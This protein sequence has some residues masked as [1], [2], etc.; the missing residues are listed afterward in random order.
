[1]HSRLRLQALLII[2]VLSI[3]IRV[4]SADAWNSPAFTTD[5]AILRQAAQ[6]VQ[7]EKHAEATVLLNELHFKFE[8]SKM[9]ETR[10][11]IHRIENQDGVKNW[12][13]I[14]GRWEAWH[15]EKPEIKARVI[16]A[17]G[18]VHW[19]DPKTL[20]DFPVHED[21]PDVYSDERSYGGPLPAVASGSI[22]EEEIAVRDMAPLF[23][24]GT[25]HRWILGW[26]APVSKT[27]VVLIHPVSLPLHYEVHLLLDATIAKSTDGGLEIITL[28]QGSLHAYTEE[29][30]HAPSD[31]VLYPE[32]EF[33]TGTSWHQVASE[34]ARLSDDQLRSADVQT[35]IAK[36][37][38]KQVADRRIHVRDRDF[39]DPVCLALYDR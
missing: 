4:S 21:A 34:H 19:L 11:L 28:E 20:N 38:A 5:P 6:A 2:V 37:K 27:R 17:E 13:E 1:M 8:H 12:A 9:M 26:G 22:V 10:H 23:A 7:A 39:A 32:I 15:Q 31:L 25:V 35:L 24:A 16:T 14:S 3:G 29:I 33:S 30:N 18:V 36:I